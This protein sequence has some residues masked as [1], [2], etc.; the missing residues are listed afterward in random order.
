MGG[1][2]ALSAIRKILIANRGE[3]AL[4]IIRTCRA[5]GI[6][7]VAV[8][9]GADR[10]SPHVRPADEAAPIGDS[11]L[12]IEEIVEAARKTGADAIHPGYGFL[13]EN[14]DFTAACESAG[15]IFI[16]PSSEVIRKM[17][18]KILARRIMA[19]AGIPVIPEAA[20]LE[21]PLLIKA[22]AGGG[23][24]G[25]RLVSSRA[26]LDGALESARREAES[27]FG[28]GTLLLEKFIP[29]ARHIEVQILGD[30]HGNLVHLFERECSIQRRHQ[31]VIEESP[32]PGLSDEL[33][34]RLFEAALRAARAIRY[35]NA[36]TV[37][38]LLAPSGEFYFME[39]NTR[40]QVEHP[41][42][43]AITGLDLV[44]LQIEIAEDR[45]LPFSQR[46]VRRSGHAMEARLYA[47]D[48]D[49]D[50]LPATGAI[51]EWDPPE[52]LRID[53]GVE[54]GSE[55]GIH[56]DPLL[57]KVISRAADRETALRR[58]ADGLRRLWIAGLQTN[59]EFLIR[60]LD[61]PDFREGK[62]HTGFIEEHLAELIAVRDPAGDYAAAVAVAFYVQAERRASRRLLRRIPPDYRNNPYRG[63]SVRLQAGHD[64]FEIRYC[65]VAADAIA[66]EPG[67]IEIEM[68]GIRHRY[69][70]A[71]AGDQFY[72]HWAGGSRVVK[73]LPRYPRHSA[74]SQVEVAQATMPG[75]VL[76]VLVE[77]RQ[78]VKAGDALIVLEAMKIEHTLRSHTD[79]IVDTILVKAGEVVAPGDLLVQI[80]SAGEAE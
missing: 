68:D 69:R 75:Q 74:Q 26:D 40:I 22:S 35:T 39:V 67:A 41:V 12:C 72:V 32:A 45:P 33:R 59:R 76:R 61:H 7:T 17:G 80:Q 28:D 31:K 56:Y 42:T 52:N 62:V 21:V 3:I 29:N 43:E 51:L 11:Y 63:P 20:D 53:S 18:S 23:G 30:R 64:T 24:R 9:S 14:A 36:G 79:G 55:I 50:F 44:R 66:F 54:K 34:H 15:F 77:E 58:L 8:Y 13:A 48:P 60:V 4:R 46:E 6:A 16:G 10:R 25:M 47:E 1:V 73:R 37:E 71:R 65:D 19:E 70:I 57:A 78:P 2:P 5:M 49:N 27:G 38:F